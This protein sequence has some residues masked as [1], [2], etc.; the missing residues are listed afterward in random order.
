MARLFDREVGC[1][2]NSVIKDTSPTTLA[3]Q[4][5]ASSFQKQ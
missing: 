2:D 5:E 3:M 1:Q 4:I